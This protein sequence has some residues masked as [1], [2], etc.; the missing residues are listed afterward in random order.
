D[1]GVYLGAIGSLD[2]LPDDVVAV[3]SLCR[4]G[5]SQVPSSRIAAEN[6]IRVWLVDSDDAADHQHVD[7]VLTEA[8][9]MVA[10][11]RAEGRV[12]LL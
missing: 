12:V 11:L 7:F 3:V 5:R 4:V 2:R 1:P 6:H 10:R 9:D 8:A